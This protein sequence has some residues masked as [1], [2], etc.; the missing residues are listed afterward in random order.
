M[1]DNLRQSLFS[2]VG[3]PPE[4]VARILESTRA[5][6]AAIDSD[7]RFRDEAKAE[8][9]AEAINATRVAFD[10]AV[11]KHAAAELKP[12]STEEGRLRA[13]LRN[14]PPLLDVDASDNIRTLALIREQRVANVQK[15][16]DL[17][18]RALDSATELA[19]VLEVFDEAEAVGGQ[20][21]RYVGK[22]AVQRAEAL[23]KG[24]RRSTLAGMMPQA[25]SSPDARL[26]TDL[27]ERYAVWAK[28]NPTT[29]QRLRQV[30]DQKAVLE[31]RLNSQRDSWLT[32]YG[33]A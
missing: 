5:K 33:L 11:Q 12:L 28:A 8:M 24:I 18:L 23:L 22:R 25:T 30:T 31:Q 7:R 16:I 21:M 17:D 14:D 26:V 15:R 19:D 32:A 6:L 4:D 3:H 10:A 13:A 9:R 29:V 20:Q 2:A 27:R 1:A